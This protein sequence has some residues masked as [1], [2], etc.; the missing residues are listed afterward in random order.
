MQ[1]GV[2]SE[3]STL[4]LVLAIFVGIAPP[5]LIQEKVNSILIQTGTVNSLD[6]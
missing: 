3:L 1:H 2:P 5:I 6:G 4:C